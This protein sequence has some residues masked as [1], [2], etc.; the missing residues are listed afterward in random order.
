MDVPS[1]PR[2]G[3]ETNI[4]EGILRYRFCHSAEFVLKKTNDIWS[5]RPVFLMRYRLVV[6]GMNDQLV[7]TIREFGDI[8][9]YNE[10]ATPPNYYVDVSISQEA[11]EELSKILGDK[12]LSKYAMMGIR[13]PESEPYPYCL[14]WMNNRESASLH[15]ESAKPEQTS[16]TLH[17][18]TADWHNKACVEIGREITMVKEG[19]NTSFVPTPMTQKCMKCSNPVPEPT[20]IVHPMC[21]PCAWEETIRTYGKGC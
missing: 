7:E 16:S 2:F 18:T 21:R 14:R 4:R 17:I 3:N 20:V 10:K 13:D 8:T 5:I 9:Y 11:M 1:P 12:L 15:R 19:E 6:R